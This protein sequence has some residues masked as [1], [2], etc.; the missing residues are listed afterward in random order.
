[1]PWFYPFIKGVIRYC[2]LDGDGTG[3]STFTHDLSKWTGT[4]FMI[5]PNIA[6]AEHSAV[7]KKPMQ[8]VKTHTRH[9][10]AW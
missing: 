10:N 8:A 3:F 6:G 1:M 5:V 9:R 4:T 2:G 7:Q